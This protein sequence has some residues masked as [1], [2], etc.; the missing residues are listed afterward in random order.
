[1]R[2]KRLLNFRM[3]SKKSTKGKE[4]ETIPTRDEGWSP[5]KCSDSVRPGTAGLLIG[6]EC[7]T[8][9]DSVW[10]YF[11]SVVTT[12]IGVELAAV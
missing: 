6:M 5:S 1:M 10:M 11:T 3:V 2:V 8:I 4:A 9:R 7:S 12:R